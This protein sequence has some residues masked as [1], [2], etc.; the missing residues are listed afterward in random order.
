MFAKKIRNYNSIMIENDHRKRMLSVVS[1]VQD[2]IPEKWKY[3]GYAIGG[4]TDVGFSRDELYL[5]VISGQGRCVFD[6]L[7]GEKIARDYNP[8]GDW[9]DTQNLTCQG[10]GPVEN[11]IIRTAGMYGGG[12]WRGNDDG[13]HLECISPEW[14]KKEIILCPDF[15]NL[16]DSDDAPYCYRVWAGY[17]PRIYGF[18]PSGLIFIIG[19]S[20]DLHIFI[21]R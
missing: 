17:E 3:I 21:M 15:R 2:G 19:E 18:S 4:L 14:P 5:I 20:S 13:D 12:L 10:I 1:G 9:F 7:T 6:C 16:Y 11:E 8:A